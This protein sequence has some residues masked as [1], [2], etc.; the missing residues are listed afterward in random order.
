MLGL[1]EI[2]STGT[3]PLTKREGEKLLSQLVDKMDLDG[4]G[5]I[6]EDEM[7]KWLKYV[8]T[9]DVEL[10]AN[11]TF[12]E[13]VTDFKTNYVT[14]EQHQ[15][16]LSEG[17]DE[18]EDA[19][20]D[21]QQTVDRDR[22]RFEKADLDGDGKLSRE[23]FAA[24]LHPEE[25]EHMRDT[26][27]LYDLDS[28]KDGLIDLEEYTKDMWTDDSQT[29]L[30][31]VQSEHQ[32]FKETRD[33]NKDGFLDREE[34][35]DWLFPAEYDHI[36]SEVKHLMSE[37]DDNLDGKLSKDEILTHYKE[38]LGSRVTDFGRAL[39]QHDEL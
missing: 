2:E 14:F 3:A 25:F 33:K 6:C 39:D 16:K 22:R 28:N 30:D 38:F 23:E 31:W 4:D 21:L 11:R 26:E 34:I 18:D 12:D 5:F 29:P 7:R 20:D 1:D 32:Q 35:R 37:T 15:T 24:F 8:E 10:D 27:T 17:Y 9:K 13:Y 19:D 36:E